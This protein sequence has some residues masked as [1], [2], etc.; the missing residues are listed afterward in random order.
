M[1]EYE[2]EYEYENN[3]P[4]LIMEGLVMTKKSR[5][6]GQTRFEF[7]FLLC[8]VQLEIQGA[9]HTRFLFS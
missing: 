2:Y 4:A 3:A 9:G 1:N 6:A 7:L 5:L 8:P